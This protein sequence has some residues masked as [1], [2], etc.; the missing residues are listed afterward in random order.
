MTVT[1]EPRPIGAR[2]AICLER[3]VLG[4]NVIGAEGKAR[5]EVHVARAVRDLLGGGPLIVSTRTSEGWRSERRGAAGGAADAVAG[6][7]LAAAHLRRRDVDVVVRG[8]RWR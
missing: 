1:R 7:E 8:V 3:R 6:D 4:L 5:A 2:S